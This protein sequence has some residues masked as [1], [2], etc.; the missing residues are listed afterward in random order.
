MDSPLPLPIEKTFENT[1]L[2]LWCNCPEYIYR[3]Y[4]SGAWPIFENYNE[5]C[6]FRPVPLSPSRTSKRGL[7]RTPATI[8]A[9]TRGQRR[10]GNVCKPTERRSSRRMRVPSP[11][12]NA[13]KRKSFARRP[14]LTLPRRVLARV[15]FDVPSHVIRACSF[16]PCSRGP[17]SLLRSFAPATRYF[18]PH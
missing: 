12:T 14:L 9:K 5:R 4:V 13:D 1:P 8:A 7:C 6:P 16:N 18:K 11:R 2:T 15:S 3:P 17:V 10:R